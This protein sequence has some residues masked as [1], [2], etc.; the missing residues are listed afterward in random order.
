MDKNF[1]V[2]NQKT[3]ILVGVYKSIKTARKIVDKKDM[4]YGSYVHKIVTI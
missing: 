1:K 2:V 4:Q 3:S